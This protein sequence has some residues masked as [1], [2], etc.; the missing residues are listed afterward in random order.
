M[1]SK[2]TIAEWVVEQLPSADVLVDVFAGGCAITHAAILSGKYK[3]VIVNDITDAP[4]LFVNA[5]K[6]KYMDRTEWISREKFF[7]LKDSDPWVR[8]CWS[9]GNNG[10]EYLYSKQIEPYKRAFHMAVV[11]RD[12]KPM[13]EQYG[14]DFSAIDNLKTIKE[15][16]IMC[17]SLVFQRYA[18]EGRMR[19]KGSHYFVDGKAVDL[20]QSSSKTERINELVGFAGLERFESLERTDRVNNI[21]KVSLKRMEVHRQDYHELHIPDN[22]I[23]YCDPPYIGK[24]GYGKK[25]TG[26]FDH[27]AFYEWCKQQT[28]PIYISE[29]TMPEPF[30]SVASKE[31]RC[32]FAQ[33]NNSNVAVEHIFT[34]PKYIQ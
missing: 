2:N 23:I 6:G 18:D 22:S 32:N 20:L 25:K 21:I 9:F 8:L 10:R 26:G 14:L 27:E 28:V 1:G 11:H 19:K 4:E 12:Y 30:V 33:Q 13:L 3:K 29:Y 7:S 31:K 16:R 17:R 34:L 24:G 15:R 5:V